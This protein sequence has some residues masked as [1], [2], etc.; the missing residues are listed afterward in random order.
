MNH[1]IEETFQKAQR[2]TR[3]INH[4]RSLYDLFTEEEISD[5]IA[6]ECG[7]GLPFNVKIIF[8]SIEGLRKAIPHHRGYWY[9]T[10][11][12]PTPGGFRMV[13]KSFVDFYLGKFRRAYEIELPL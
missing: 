4:V 2:E 8:Q 9:F 1:L 7:S 12:Y 13:N 3:P 10:G 6:R 11:E 5:E